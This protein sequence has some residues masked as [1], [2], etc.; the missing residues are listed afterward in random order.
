M[1]PSEGPSEGQNPQNR[2]EQQGPRLLLQPRS[3]AD[4]RLSIHAKQASTGLAAHPKDLSCHLHCNCQVLGAHV[5]SAC[6][7]AWDAE[8]EDA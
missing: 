3:P 7:L 4:G 5:H 1:R 8:A 6:A 2:T